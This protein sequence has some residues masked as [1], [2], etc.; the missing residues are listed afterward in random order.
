MPDELFFVIMSIPGEYRDLLTR[1]GSLDDID[2][3]LRDRQGSTAWSALERIAH[4]ADSLHASAK[5]VVAVLDGDRARYTPVHIDAARAGSNAQPSRAVLASLDAAATD[6]ARV[7]GRVRGDDWE[8]TIVLGDHS[9][10]VRGLLEAALGEARQH[11]S[12]V[13]ALLAGARRSVGVGP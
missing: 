12:D 1:H 5:C 7:A 11:L 4:V 10:N 13:D 3:L 2:A 6:L 9:T 8:R